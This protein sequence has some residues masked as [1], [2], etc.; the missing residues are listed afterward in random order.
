MWTCE[1]TLTWLCKNVLMCLF[2]TVFFLWHLPHP[3]IYMCTFVLRTLKFSC[4][5]KSGSLK[6]HRDRQSCLLHTVQRWESRYGSFFTQAFPLLCCCPTECNTMNTFEE[7]LYESVCVLLVHLTS[8]TAGFSA[9]LSNVFGWHVV[10]TGAFHAHSVNSHSTFNGNPAISLSRCLVTDK[11]LVKRKVCCGD[12]KQRV[13]VSPKSLFLSFWAPLTPI[14]ELM[15]IWTGV[16]LDLPL[17]QSVGTTKRQ[18]RP[19]TIVTW[20]KKSLLFV[21]VTGNSLLQQLIKKTQ[22]LYNCYNT[23]I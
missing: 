11:M 2:D 3:L 1:L 17:D 22:V 12:A 14:S 10:Q 7:R 13:R 5:N 15:E 9:H 4:K 21:V 20:I 23:Q 6:P 18:E 19:L 16:V 8:M